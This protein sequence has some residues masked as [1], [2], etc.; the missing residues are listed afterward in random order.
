[1]RSRTKHDDTRLAGAIAG[2]LARITPA[3]LVISLVHFIGLRINHPR[4]NGV[5]QSVIIASAGLLLASCIPLGAEALTGPITIG[6]ATVTVVLLIESEIDTLWLI[7]GAAVVA[8]SASA[9]GMV[10]RL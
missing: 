1:M 6:I 5:L 7:L 3:L 9:I 4:V 10:D 8:W 2:W